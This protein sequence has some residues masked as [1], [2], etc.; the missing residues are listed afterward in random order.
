[1]SGVDERFCAKVIE[2]YAAQQE[3]QLEPKDHQRLVAA[4]AARAAELV[5]RVR[6]ARAVLV[7]DPVGT[8]KTVVALAA[9]ARLCRNHTVDRILIVA[10]NA[11][12]AEQW[13]HRARQVRQGQYFTKVARHSAGRRQRWQD[14][15][16]RVVTRRALTSGELPAPTTDGVKYLVIVD[17]AHRGLQHRSGFHESLSAWRNVGRLML[18][19]ATPFQMS[20]TGLTT[21]LEVGHVQPDDIEQLRSYG[22]A[23]SDAVG[24]QV[25]SGTGPSAEERERLRELASQAE[26]VLARYRGTKSLATTLKVPR[27]PGLDAPAS[28]CAVPTAPAWRDAFEVARLVPDLV[29][30]H[31]GDA[32]QRRLVSSSEAFWSGA[33]GSELD[34]LASRNRRVAALVRHLRAELGS[35]V[36]HPK[37]CHTVEQVARWASDP[38]PRH[39][40]VFCVWEE[41]AQVIESE[42]AKRAK[43]AFAV[44]RPDKT[45]PARVSRQLRT[46]PPE[47]TPMVVI[48]QDRFSESIDLDGG[49]PF[50]IHHDLPWN[51]ARIRQRWGRVV[52][53]S[54]G[55]EPVPPEG[56]NVPVLD[57][58]TDKR[59]HAT[60]L[61]RAR[62]GDNILLPMSD[63]EDG[64]EA[65]EHDDGQLWESGAFEL[66]ATTQRRGGRAD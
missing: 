26:V 12:V 56:I 23:A 36:E 18:V 7:D 38:E 53:A 50:L 54:S 39:V 49:R 63:G 47:S 11:T 8:G 55:F 16:V 13:E 59:L 6:R 10:P 33:A 65:G 29:G 52:R 61:N 35:G 32:F 48:L 57:V 28:M 2:H 24:R 1:M 41:T 30:A 51:P 31:N 44:E 9:A 62:I 15:M 40:L 3:R 42:L 17:E 19:T 37:V 25:D 27:P 64:L 45:V 46:P 66:L 22:R 58:H 43:G 21:M 34:A 60:V 14:G 20:M 4:Q 5:E